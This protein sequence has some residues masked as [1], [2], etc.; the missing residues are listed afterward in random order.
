MRRLPTTL[1]IVILSFCQF[2]G[3]SETVAPPNIVFLLADDLGWTGLGCFGS[4]FYETPHLDTLAQQG[5]RFTD[6][7]SACTVCSPTRASIM[8]GLYPARLRLT[9]FI[10]GQNRPF[11]RMRIPEWTKRLGPEHTTI[12]EVL[13][14]SGYRTAHVG[15]WHLNGKGENSFETTPINQGFDRSISSPSGTKG[16]F[17]QEGT[18][19]EEGTN[20]LTDYLTDHACQFIKESDSDPFFLYFAYNVPHTPIQGAQRLSQIL[21]GQGKSNEDTSQSGVCGN[22]RKLGSKCRTYSR[23]S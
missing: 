14:N 8:T 13:K 4:D 17:L 1:L 20:Y 7:Y 10:A 3:A 5:V 15:K 11:A 19:S 2:C 6:A 22:G 12:A 9:D 18:Q 23:C 21:R 16:Y